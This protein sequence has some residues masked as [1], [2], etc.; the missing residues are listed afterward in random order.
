MNKNSRGFAHLIILIIPVL[1]GLGLVGYLVLKQSTLS[2]PAP[3]SPTDQTVDWKTYTNTSFNYSFKYP[4]DWY[5]KESPVALFNFD[6]EDRYIYS[7]D[8]LENHDNPLFILF[9]ITYI[10]PDF[11]N[12]DY[13]AKQKEWNKWA[14]SYKKQGNY[15][16]QI[17]N[18]KKLHFDNI[19][20]LLIDSCLDTETSSNYPCISETLIPHGDYAIWITIKGNINQ[21]QIIDQILSTFEF[22]D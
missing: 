16:Y 7:P 4:Q 17:T 9:D 2:Q 12:L 6:P 20:T 13:E 3:T 10:D 11:K 5:L 19:S 1:I 18:E 15:G 14:D 8:F 21:T 22:I